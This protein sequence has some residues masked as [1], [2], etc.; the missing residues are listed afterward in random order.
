VKCAFFVW[1]LLKIKG[2]EE[3][4]PLGF[5]S[6]Q[7]VKCRYTFCLLP[8]QAGFLHGIFYDPEDGGNMRLKL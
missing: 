1:L 8:A 2:T 7:S 5:S 4:C 3:F 6:V